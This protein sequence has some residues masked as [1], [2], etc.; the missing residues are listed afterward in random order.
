[1][2]LKSSRG[3]GEGEGG[4]GGEGREGGGRLWISNGAAHCVEVS[5]VLHALCFANCMNN[6]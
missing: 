3:G 1:M 4:G 2:F 5:H 6:Q